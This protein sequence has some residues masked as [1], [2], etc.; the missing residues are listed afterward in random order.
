M[1]R[2]L[3]D[4]LGGGGVF[5][6]DGAMGTMLQTAGLKPGA[7]GELWNMERPEVVLG[8]HAAYVTAGSCVLLTNTFGGNRFRLAL[9][10]AE[11]RVREINGAGAALA[12]KAAGEEGF[13]LGD[14]GPFGGIL[15]PEGDADPDAVHAAFLEQAE[16]LVQAGV[17][18]LIVETQVSIDEMR[19]ALHAAREAGA[20]LVMASFAFD[21]TRPGAYRTMMGVSPGDAA[22]AMEDAGADVFGCNCGKD[23]GVAE[24]AAI[25]RAY[26]GLTSKPILIKP[27]A[28]QPVKTGDGFA[29]TEPPEKMAPS[30]P[31]LIEAGAR[32]IGGC[33][34]TTPR[35][36]ELFRVA[37]GLP[38]S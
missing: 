11:S 19:L 23:I 29:Y 18:G 10:S 12:R 17:D 15:A 26:R 13:V 8:I 36:I 3:L 34:G 37:L 4:R 1:A 35:H 22:A 5:L 25:A 27:N 6:A 14:I 30:A 21:R 28:G 16:A 2:D 33:C 24:A 32:I 38:R 31:A 7:C 20:R 9:H